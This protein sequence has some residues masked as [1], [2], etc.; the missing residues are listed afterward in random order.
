MHFSQNQHADFNSQQH[1]IMITFY[2][3]YPFHF[4]YHQFNDY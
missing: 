2:K 3:F 1:L 4:D